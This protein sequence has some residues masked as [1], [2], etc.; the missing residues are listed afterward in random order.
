V[1]G[2][3]NGKEGLILIDPAGDFEVA[4]DGTAGVSSVQ[5]DVDLFFPNPAVAP[6]TGGVRIGAR[7]LQKYRVTVC[8]QEG[9]I[10]FE[11]PDADK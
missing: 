3:V 1:R 9:M 7:L 2:L 6:S 11:K 10:Y 5:L 8:P 4:A